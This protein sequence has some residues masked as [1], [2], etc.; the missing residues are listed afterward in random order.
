M[1]NPKFVGAPLAQRHALF[2]FWWDFMMG[3]GEPEQPAN[4]E[5]AMFSRCRN[6]KGERLNFREL[7]QTMQGHAH[8]SSACDFMTGLCKPKLRT[9]FEVASFSRCRNVKGEPQ[10]FRELPSP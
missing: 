6:I 3:F 7:P 4:F 5:V 1:E 9:K 8:F 2:F 10:N